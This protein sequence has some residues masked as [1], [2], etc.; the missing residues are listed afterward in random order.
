MQRGPAKESIQF[1]VVGSIWGF[2]DKTDGTVID[3]IQ[4]IEQGIGGYFVN[5]I[6]EVEDQQD[7]QYYEGMFGSVSEGGFVAK[8]EAD[9]RFNVGLEMFNV[10][11]EGEFTGQQDT[12]VFVVVHIF[13]V[14][15]IQSSD[16]SR[17]GWFGQQTV[18]KHAFCFTSI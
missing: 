4:F 15:T 3:C 1:A 5:D 9:S 18:E 16:A 10:S 11:L 13:L 7:S 8:Q 2:G 14:R 12:Q 6:T 17:A